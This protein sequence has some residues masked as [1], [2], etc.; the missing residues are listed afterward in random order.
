MEHQQIYKFK[1]IL[2]G[3]TSSPPTFAFLT[4]KGNPSSSPALQLAADTGT[5][6]HFVQCPEHMN[7][8]LAYDGPMFNVTKATAPINVTLPDNSTMANTHEGTLRIPGV[9]P[10]ASKA[11]IFS[12]MASS[13]LSIGQLCD[14]GCIALF[15]KCRVIII[16]DNAVILMGRRDPQTKLWVVDL[17]DAPTMEPMPGPNILQYAANAAIAKETVAERIAFLHWCAGSP[18]LSTFCKAIDAGYFRSWPQL[19]SQLVRKHLPSSIPMIKGHLDQQ[20]KNIKSTKKP[21]RATAKPIRLPGTDPK[22]P[23][24]PLVAV[25]K[26]KR[27]EDVARHESNLALLR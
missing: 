5:T 2:S 18:Q 12:N 15:D 9:S 17:D 3:S 14:D 23:C 13:L 19:T 25:P 6:G 1:D 7:D 21:T 24:A 22:L 8:Y 27:D 11:Y 20:R 16:K 26:P 4:K 10:A